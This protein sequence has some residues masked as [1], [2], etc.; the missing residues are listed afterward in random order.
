MSKAQYTGSVDIELEYRDGVAT[1]RTTFP[2][3]SMQESDLGPL[4][5]FIDDDHLASHIADEIRADASEIAQA[6]VREL[7]KLNRGG[8]Q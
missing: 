5:Y 1:L 7:R 8:S 3:A 6:L 4:S 2:P